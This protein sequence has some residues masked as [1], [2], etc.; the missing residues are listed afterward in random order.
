MMT[1]YEGPSRVKAGQGTDL[2]FPSHSASSWQMARCRMKAPGKSKLWRSA[3]GTGRARDRSDKQKTHLPA[4]FCKGRQ[5]DLGLNPGCANLGSHL[6]FSTLGFFTCKWDPHL[7]T[8]GIGG[9]LSDGSYDAGSS[10][11][12]AL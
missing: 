8:V 10:R 12:R 4:V 5:T 11:C 9:C 1:Y 3:P 6:S 7:V 2:N